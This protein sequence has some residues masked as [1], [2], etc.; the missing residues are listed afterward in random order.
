M[1]DA[2]GVRS[3]EV[4]MRAPKVLKALQAKAAGKEPRVGP[5]KTP[6]VEWPEAVRVRTPAEGGDGRASER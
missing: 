4:P 5:T 3:D 2:V 6:V 1:N